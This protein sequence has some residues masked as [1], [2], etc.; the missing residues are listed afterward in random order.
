M[1]FIWKNH[2]PVILH[3]NNRPAFS[4]RFIKRLEFRFDIAA[5]GLPGGDTVDLFRPGTHE[6]DAATGNNAGLETIAPETGEQLEHC[7]KT[8]SLQNRPVFGC[9][10][11]PSQSS[12]ICANSSVVVPA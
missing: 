4:L 10:A 2:I 7:S 6:L 9:L 5:E 12:T 1:T 8:I 11:L 3:V